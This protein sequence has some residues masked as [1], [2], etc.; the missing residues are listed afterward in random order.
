MNKIKK[1]QPD[2]W[3]IY[4][5]SDLIGALFKSKDT[6]GRNC[7]RVEFTESN[8]TVWGYYGFETAKA[9]AKFGSYKA[10]KQA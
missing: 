4:N 8:D 9:V 10:L 6:Q 1:L 5:G 3:Q 7:Y 2:L